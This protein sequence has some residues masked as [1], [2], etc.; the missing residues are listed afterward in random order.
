M[1]LDICNVSIMYRAIESMRYEDGNFVVR[2]VSGAEYK[3][4][5]LDEL[6]AS[7]LI[8]RVVEAMALCESL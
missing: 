4:P 7:N 2:T 3:K 5:M 8:N 6:Q 1:K